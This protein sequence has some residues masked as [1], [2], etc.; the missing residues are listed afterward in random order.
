VWEP[1]VILVEA[2]AGQFRSDGRLGKT[3]WLKTDLERT[4]GSGTSQLARALAYINST[5]RPRFRET[6]TGRTRS[7]DMRQVCRTFPLLVTQQELALAARVGDVRDLRLLI[8]TPEPVTLTAANLDTITRFCAGPEVFLHY[9]ERRLAVQLGP[10]ELLADEM[11]LFGAYLDNR[12]R[13]FDTLATAA[14]GLPV[15]IAWTALSERFD[16]ESMHRLAGSPAGEPIRLRLP[17]G[18]EAL[19]ADL[20]TTGDAGSR[21][22]AFE[23]LDLTDPEMLTL[24]AALYRLRT[25][26]TP[27]PGML[28]RIVMEEGGL[29]VH[30]MGA[31]HGTL[32]EMKEV[33]SPRT[34]DEQRRRGARAALGFGVDLGTPG[35]P[36]VAAVWSGEPQGT[37]E[38]VDGPGTEPALVRP[39]MG[40]QPPG[41]NEPCWCGSGRKHKRCCL[42]RLR[43]SR[44]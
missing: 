42:G 29:L 39:V 17:P 20:R 3:Q 43:S 31:V 6:K 7:L 40:W 11:N 44:S 4:V 30:V 22:I 19:L 38:K 16:T 35:Q 15:S 5:N 23:L 37:G 28:R 27:E 26:G 14:G 18:L 13:L 10:H 24:A 33:L 12:L 1:F 21:R 9:L 36:V 32:A 41:R 34:I 2:K 25:D 8:G